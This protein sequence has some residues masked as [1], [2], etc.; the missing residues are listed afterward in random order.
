M[1]FKEALSTTQTDI[2][3]YLQN[4]MS[5]QTGIPEPLHSAMTYG[6]L[7]PGKRL[8]PFLLRYSAQLFDVPWEQCRPLAAA[9][10]MVHAYSLIHD[11]M[12]AMDNSPLRR[13]QPTVHCKFDEATALLAGNSLFTYAIEHMAVQPMHG[14]V[15]LNLISMLCK[16][17]GA[18]GMM[19]GQMLD[20]GEKS[21]QN[22]TLEDITHLQALKTGQLLSYA[23]LCASLLGHANQDQEKALHLYAQNIG[24]AF[25]ITDDL[26]DVCGEQAV[27]GKPLRVDLN[28]HKVTFVSLLGESEARSKAQGLI[29]D[30]ITNLERTF[31]E[32]GY[33]KDLALYILSRNS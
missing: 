32:I 28:Q 20:M 18:A 23:C 19:G 8:R 9:L 2:D 25:Q 29:E 1:T 17:S 15:K 27:V 3:T 10:E 21:P 14:D 16:A 33:L 22:T 24:L 7:T 6:L 12:P 26:L 5:K 4:L 31:G 13:G 30:G 11:D